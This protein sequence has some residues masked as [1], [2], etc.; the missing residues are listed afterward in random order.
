MTM[1]DYEGIEIELNDTI[2]VEKSE[3]IVKGFGSCVIAQGE[4]QKI[5]ITERAEDGELIVWSEYEIGRYE[6]KN[7]KRKYGVKF[8]DEI[9]EAE[10]YSV[11]NAENIEDAI[12]A[13]KRI[14]SDIDIIEVRKM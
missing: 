12:K 3:Y 14:N 9:R 4:S 10:R 2:R 7:T 8:F 13:V 1:K 6:I 5:L 11:L